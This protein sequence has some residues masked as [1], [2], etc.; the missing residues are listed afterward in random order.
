MFSS[1]CDCCIHYAFKGMNDERRCWKWFVRVCG[2][3][4]AYEGFVVEWVSER[5]S[6]KELLLIG[7]GKWLNKGTLC[8]LGT[9][10][11]W[12]SRARCVRLSATLVYREVY[13]E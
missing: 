8:G 12:T 6:S 5:R 13:R 1:M 11:K 9:L 10:E 4:V 7:F 3:E 2:L